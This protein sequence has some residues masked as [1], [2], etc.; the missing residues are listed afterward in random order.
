MQAYNRLIEMVAIGSGKGMH[1]LT[2]DNFNDILCGQHK[3]VEADVASII[4][5][6]IARG[7]LQWDQGLEVPEDQQATLQED[8]S[9]PSNAMN[10]ADQWRESIEN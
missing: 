6:P 2:E 10:L 4:A 9:N 5:S 8:P 1:Q 3:F 7:I